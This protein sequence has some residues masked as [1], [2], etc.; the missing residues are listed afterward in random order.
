MNKI[1]LYIV[2]SILI[3]SKVNAAKHFVYVDVSEL[4]TIEE[5]KLYSLVDSLVTSFNTDDFILYFSN[6]NYPVVFFDKNSYF[7]NKKRL[8]VELH[9]S[10]PYYSFEI[11]TINKL[12]SSHRFI[13]E[14]QQHSPESFNNELTFHFIMNQNHSIEYQQIKYLVDR[15]LLSNRLMYDE[16]VVK[17]T[18][19]NIY[20]QVDEYLNFKEEVKNRCNERKYA[21]V[22]Y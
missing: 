20:C 8:D 14:I 15:I 1:Y 4:D 21:I 13:S 16:C 12:F 19:V 11:D 9:P 22:K 7:L 6:D 3:C 2:L 10:K 18:F 5:K 17:G